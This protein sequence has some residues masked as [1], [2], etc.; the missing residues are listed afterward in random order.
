MVHIDQRLVIVASLI[1]PLNHYF[2]NCFINFYPFAGLLASFYQG[3][4]YKKTMGVDNGLAR[5]KGS[6]DGLVIVWVG[7]GLLSI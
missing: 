1:L 6:T 2:I 5:S 4:L 3:Q 7:L